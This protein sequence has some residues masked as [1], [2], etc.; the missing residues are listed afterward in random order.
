MEYDQ[1]FTRY[2]TKLREE[3]QRKER[4][5]LFAC[6]FGDHAL[7]LHHDLVEEEARHKNADVMTFI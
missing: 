6:F 5:A 3:E 1:C 7:P 2:E 4:P